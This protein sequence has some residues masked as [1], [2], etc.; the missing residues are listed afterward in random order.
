MFM[1]DLIF[2][3]SP[4]IVLG[5]YTLTRLG[6]YVRNYGSKFMVILDPI[7]KDFNLAEK[8]TQPL[9]ERKID[10]FVYDN[11]ND[12]ATT[13]DIE[14]AIILAQQSHIHGIIAAG[15]EKAINAGCAIASLINEKRSI[16]DFIDGSVP[17]ET[18][19]PLVCLPST[20]RAPYAF[21]N[22]IPLIDSRSRQVKQLKTQSNVCRLMLWDPNLALTLTEN[23]TAS[24]SLETLCIACEAYLSQKA[25]FFSDMF[26]EKAFEILS[27]ATDGKKSLDIS[28]PKELLLA[29]GG[30][31]A[32]LAASASS[33]G[34]ASLIALTVNARYKIS[35]SLVAAIVFPYMIEE[36]AKFKAEKI[37]KI[38]RILNPSEEFSSNEN[39]AQT[40]AESIRQKL[41]KANLPTRLKDLNLTMEQLAESAEDAGQLDIMTML[42]RSMTTDE[43][44]ELMKQA[45]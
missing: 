44:F 8:I 27:Y 11:F 43:L 9:T 22:S 7:L 5:S 18:S 3:I 26:C 35:R 45:Y 23:Q 19:I 31:M 2:K 12:G 15:G 42:P 38:A 10:F 20:C 14:K 40:F 21:T 6:Q 32:S 34:I 36:T 1:A 24:L 39:A 16:Y 13:K 33:T 28:A 17:T 25:T 29:Q 30:C 37:A 41:A 4:N